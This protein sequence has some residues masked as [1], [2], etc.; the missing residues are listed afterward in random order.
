MPVLIPPPQ[1]SN[2][3]SRSLFFRLNPEKGK[4]TLD[5][6]ANVTLKAHYDMDGQVLILPIRGNGQAKIKIS[7]YQHHKILLISKVQKV[8]KVKIK[9]CLTFLQAQL[10]NSVGVW[11]NHYWPVNERLLPI[12]VTVASIAKETS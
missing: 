6:T 1:T 5:F 2:H 12:Y 9:K 3:Q 10:N 7:E 8:S 4:A 11:V